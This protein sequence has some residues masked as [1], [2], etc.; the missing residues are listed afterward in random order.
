MNKR[1]SFYI[2]AVLIFSFCFP[3][4]VA[5]YIHN[6]QP[7][8]DSA[9]TP[10]YQIVAKINEKYGTDFHISSFEETVTLTPCE[11]EQ[12]MENFAMLATSVETPNI[13]EVTLP[14]PR[15]RSSGPYYEVVPV[16]IN[17]FFDMN[18]E[19]AY[20]IADN[21]NDLYFVQNISDNRYT[22]SS[23]NAFTWG[24]VEVESYRDYVSSDRIKVFVDLVA[25][26]YISSG[27]IVILVDEINDTYRI[28]INDLP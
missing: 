15:A 28:H 1:F 22:F 6:G 2:A 17:S 12:N 11:F 9:Y 3:T 4:S 27:G 26:C 14:L 8:Y 21:G 23:T 19:V 10:Y 25:D 5:A 16:R 20:K 7:D 24:H 18:V 13:V